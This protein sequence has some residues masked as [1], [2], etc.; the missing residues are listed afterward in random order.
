VFAL[1][2]MSAGCGRVDFA[3]V[4]RDAAVALPNPIGWWQLADGVGT[5][6]ADSSGYGNAGVLS[7]GITWT[8]GRSG[9]AI[10][11]DGAA[12]HQ[13]DL[14]DPLRLHLSGSMTLVAW[15]NNNAVSDPSAD[16]AIISRDDFAGNNFGWA[17]KSSSDCGPAHWVMQIAASA[18]SVPERCSTSVPTTGVWYHVAGVYDTTGPALHIYV[19]GVLDDGSLTVDVPAMQY[20]PTSP[21]HAEIG[22]ADPLP[23]GN[24]TGGPNTFDGLIEDVRVYDVALDP[25][26]IAALARM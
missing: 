3:A 25:E 9:G 19:N 17:L 15:V 23:V 5:N 2:A 21:L 22:N 11:I 26:Q 6:A 7:A 1:V 13:I 24:L 20:V 8:A 14:G 10:S 16:R 12:D 18:T 4:P